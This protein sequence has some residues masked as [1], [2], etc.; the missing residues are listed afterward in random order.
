MRPERPARVARCAEA[1]AGNYQSRRAADRRARD[2]DTAARGHANTG[3]NTGAY[4]GA[5]TGSNAYP[6]PHVI[7]G[8]STDVIADASAA[9]CRARF[10]EPNKGRQVF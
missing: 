6:K 2:C 3:A 10:L 9:G 5:S 4:F 1:Q 8:A 7:A